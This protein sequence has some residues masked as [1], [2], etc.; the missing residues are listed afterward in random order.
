VARLRTRW[1]CAPAIAATVVATVGCSSRYIAP[2]AALVHS[3]SN[4]GT[5]SQPVVVVARF[6][7]PVPEVIPIKNVGVELG[8]ALGRMLARNDDVE[9]W[10][11]P[12]IG[13][14]VGGIVVGS[15]GPRE[16]A[17]GQLR[18]THPRVRYVVLGQVTDFRHVQEE[19]R[20]FMERWFVGKKQ[21]A[22]V[23]IEFQVIDVKEERTVLTHHVLATE[24]AGDRSVGTTYN[25][26]VSNSY[27]FWNTPLGQ[28]GAQAVRS[29]ADVIQD[30]GSL[31]AA[32][33]EIRVL[34]QADAR[35][36]R[37]STG[38]R[39]LIPT[40]EYYVCRYRHTDGGLEPVIDAQTRRPLQA[41][42]RKRGR[43]TATAWLHGRAESGSS[44][45]GAILLPELPLSERPTDPLASSGQAGSP[46]IDARR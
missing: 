44:L 28:A 10:F 7:D 43:G 41:V 39:R 13:R 26:V 8:D 46:A 23:A 9:V 40:G 36:L 30:S 16:S 42:I 22:L 20:N 32:H 18:R 29:A 24:D 38:G 45:R 5:G 11:D 15:S 2:P 31:E 27:L 4:P 14:S 1:L 34:R 6:N 35:Q 17:F 19:P 37:V 21:K 3:A 25:G 33:G 12:G